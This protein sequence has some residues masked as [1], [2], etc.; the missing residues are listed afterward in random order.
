MSRDRFMCIYNTLHFNRNPEEG[1]PRPEDPL[2]KIRPVMDFFNNRMAEIYS[3]GKNLCIGESMVLWK[4]RL[5]FRLYVKGKKHKFGIKLYVLTE[6]D[7][8]ERVGIKLYVLTESDGTV[9]NFFIYAGAS[10]VLLGG[11]GHADEVVENLL[12]GKFE[13][14]HSVFM[15]NYYNSVSLAKKLAEKC[16]FCTGTLRSNRKGNPSDVLRKKLKKGECFCQGET[17]SP[18]NISR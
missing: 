12:E 2:F 13:I 8:T 6:S 10:D 15:D 3:P 1:K 16:C 9:F 7:G 5:K 4:G 18:I 14:N 11:K 17:S